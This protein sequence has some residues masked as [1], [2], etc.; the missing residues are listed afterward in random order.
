MS[1]IS[2]KNINSVGPRGFKKF[3]NTNINKFNNSNDML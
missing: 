3:E 1:K 2:T